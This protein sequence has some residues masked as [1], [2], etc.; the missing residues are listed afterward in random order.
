MKREFCGGDVTMLETIFE[1]D[2]SCGEMGGSMTSLNI[3]K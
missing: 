1:C 2:F 3:E